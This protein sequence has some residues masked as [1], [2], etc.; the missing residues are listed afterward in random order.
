LLLT[1][2]SNLPIFHH[3]VFL[4]WLLPLNLKP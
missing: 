2:Y 1:Q 3:S 4:S